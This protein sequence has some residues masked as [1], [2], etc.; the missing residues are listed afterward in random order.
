MRGF[1]AVVMMM[2]CAFSAS[3]QV[4]RMET[5][6]SASDQRIP[7]AIPAF[8][9]PPGQEALGQELAAIVAY[10]LDFS[11][12][13]RVLPRDSYPAGFAGSPRD[14]SQID[15]AAWR[16]SK[17]DYFLHGYV[18][19]S[20]STLSFECQLFDVIDSHR[21]LGKVHEGGQQAKRRIAHRA[22]DDIL[23]QVDGIEGI[24][25][26]AVA[27]S[28]GSTGRKEIYMADYDG[29]NARQLTH[30]N[31]I[32]ILPKISPDGGKIAY[33]SFRQGAP[34]LYV[35][36]IASGSSTLL[37]KMVGLNI[38]P[39]WAPDG[40]TLAITLSKDA[41]PEIYLINPDGT[42]LRRLTNDKAVDTQ[43]AFSPDGRQIAFVSDR[44]GSGQICV[45]NADGSGVRRLSMQGGRST[46][47]AWS[48]DGKS[49]AYAV[50]GGGIQIYVMDANGGNPRQLTRAG[51]NEKPSWSA[52]SRHVVFTSSRSGSSSL[53]A[54]NIKTGQ[55]R[56]IP[57]LQM[58]CQ[59]PSWGP[60]R[61]SP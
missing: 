7:I 39:S 49:I 34:C 50:E 14:P 47:P 30:Y 40:R 29:M 31:S 45:M 38:S 43:P 19:T 13:F 54:V 2:A 4:L 18:Y 52:D 6:G 42:G 16:A 56:R 27:F 26:S 22:S 32:S 36:S 60:R 3:A 46:D 15:F 21:V 41:N 8:S 25:T 9:A 51:N 57:N 11:G 10:D 24:A 28:G 35:L 58:A 61:S 23:L 55:E 1:F 5:V 59:G 12:V 17:A 20:G 37:S 44:Y 53:W 48:P 33:T